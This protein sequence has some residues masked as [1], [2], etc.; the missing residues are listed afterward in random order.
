[1]PWAEGLNLV[2]AELYHVQDIYGNAAVYTSCCADTEVGCWSPY[3]RRIIDGR[4][5][6]VHAES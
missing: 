3:D 4:D 5:I 2:T 6:F 1:V